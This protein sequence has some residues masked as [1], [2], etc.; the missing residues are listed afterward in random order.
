M[1]K[2]LIVQL[3]CYILSLLCSFL[4]WDWGLSYSYRLHFPNSV[5]FYCLCGQRTLRIWCPLM[6]W[7]VFVSFNTTCCCFSFSYLSHLNGL[8]WC[9]LK[10]VHCNNFFKTCSLLLW[11]IC[12]GFV[13][14]DKLLWIRYFWR[15]SSIRS[16][17][18]HGGREV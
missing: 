6:E 1:V 11:I 13:Y 17:E 14:M 4:V 9:P 15:S 18:A 12:H 7:F 8:I 3:L 10:P 2:L 16:F 5:Y